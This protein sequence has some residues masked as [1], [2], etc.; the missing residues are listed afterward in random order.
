MKNRLRVG[1][2]V[3]QKVQFPV[4]GYT[5]LLGVPT[6]SERVQQISP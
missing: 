3:K 2:A 4:D 6:H 5:G 1:K